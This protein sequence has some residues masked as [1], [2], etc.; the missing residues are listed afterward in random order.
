MDEENVLD[1]LAALSQETRLRIV[2]YLIQRGEEGAA[3]GEVGKQV[4]ASSSRASF[5]LSALEQ[6]G[7]ISSE[8][9][10]RKIIYRADIGNLGGLV[11]FLLN[12]C[13]DNHPD[14]LACCTGKNGCC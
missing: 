13:C 14:I 12:D 2:R 8:R 7:V 5:H 1:M 4:E 3:A 10:S 11:S 6:A 9:Q